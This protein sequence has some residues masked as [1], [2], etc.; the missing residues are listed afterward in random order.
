MALPA[1]Q[2]LL[3]STRIYRKQGVIADSLRG[4]LDL[5]PEV[6]LADVVKKKKKKTKSK[7][8][9]PAHMHKY[10]QRF[11]L[12]EMVRGISW[13]W[14]GYIMAAWLC[15]VPHGAFFIFNFHWCIFK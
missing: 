7:Q 5:A 11:A 8:K 4:L 10:I 14:V 13:I 12:P 9:K 6:L 2:G 3:V 15:Q 1:C